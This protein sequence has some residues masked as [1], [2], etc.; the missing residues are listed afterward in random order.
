MSKIFKYRNL[1]S[2][3]ITISLL[4]S[5]P[6]FALAANT[7]DIKEQLSVVIQGEFGPA[8][9]ETYVTGMVQDNFGNTYIVGVTKSQF[10][11]EDS[12]A[13]RERVFLAKF[14]EDLEM[15][16][17]TVLI[18]D[19]PTYS[20]EDYDFAKEEKVHY[21]GNSFHN[22]PITTDAKGNIYIV[23]QEK[24][25]RELT[26][27]IEDIMYDFPDDCICWMWCDEYDCDF[28][29][30]TDCPVCNAFREFEATFKEG[31]SLEYVLYKF[32]SSIEEKHKFIIASVQGA[33]PYNS[34][35]IAIEIDDDGY[36]YVGGGTEKDL[37][38]ADPV[39]DFNYFDADPTGSGKKMDNTRGFLVKINPSMTK[40]AASTY[41]GGPLAETQWSS[42]PDCYVTAIAADSGYIYVA[43]TDGGG[44][45]PTVAEDV[46][47][48]KT[49]N[50]SDVYIV[51]FNRDDLSI[52]KATYYGGTSSDDVTQLTV[53][54]A[55]YSGMVYI[56]GHTTS[57]TIPTHSSAFQRSL[58]TSEANYRDAF[59]ARFSKSLEMD[60]SF[61]ATY[62]GGSQRE[63][64]FGMDV[65]DDG[66][67][68]IT[69]ETYGSY[70]FPTTDGT[71]NSDGRIFI[72]KLNKDFSD[73]VVST[74][75]GGDPW[76]GDEQ[77]RAIKAN[78]DGIVVAGQGD[79]DNTD[80]A[81]P[82][83]S[84]YNTTLSHSRVIKMEATPSGTSRSPIYMGIGDVIDIKVIFDSY[85]AV[86]TTNG[87]PRIKL[88]VGENSYA[89]Y[90]SGSGTNTLTFKYTIVEGDTT[91]GEPLSC[92][93]F[94]LEL[95]GGTI[96]PRSGGTDE[97]INLNLPSDDLSK[98]YIYVSTVPISVDLISSSIGEGTYGTGTV[99]PIT[100][101][102]KDKIL[103]VDT[104]NGTPELSLNNGGKAVFVEKLK[105]KDTDLI[106]NYTVGENQTID[107]LNIASEDALS[108]NGAVIKDYYGIT[109]NLTLPSPDPDE[110]KR[111]LKGKGIRINSNA[112][113][114][115]SVT[116]T[117]E[118]GAYTVGQEI[119]ITLNFDK[120]INKTGTISL[121]INSKKD[122]GMISHDQDIENSESITFNYVVQD[123]DITKDGYLDYSNEFLVSQDGELTS[124]D[125][126]P[127]SITMPKPGSEKSLST[128]KIIIDTETP[129]VQYNYKKPGVSVFKAGDEITLEAQFNE[130]V[131]LNSDITPYV[132]VDYTTPGEVEKARFEYI[133]LKPNDPKTVL[134]RYTVKDEDTL[135]KK[136]VDYNGWTIAPKGCFVDIAGN[137]AIL[138]LPY[139]ASPM[140]R[141]WELTFDTVSPTWGEG[142]L[143]CTYDEAKEAVKIEWPKAVDDNSGIGNYYYIY[144][145][146]KGKD[147]QQISSRSSSYTSYEDK[148]IVPGTTYIYSVYVEDKA[149]NRSEPLVSEEITIPGEKPEEDTMPPYW[150]SG[151][152]LIGERLS[153]TKAKLSWNPTMAVDDDGEVDK[154]EIHQKINNTWD[155]EPL[156][157]IR[158]DELY[159]VKE[160][161]IEGI[162]NDDYEFGIF[163]VDGA[164]HKSDEPLTIVVKR[165]LP[166]MAVVDI[167]TQTIKKEYLLGDLVKMDIKNIRYSGL[168]DRDGNLYRS[169]YG[170]TGI[171]LETI[172]EDLGLLESYTRMG[173][174]AFDMSVPFTLTKEQ[175]EGE[176]YYFAGSAENKLPVKPMIA[177]FY[178]EKNDSYNEPPFMEDPNQMPP[179][180]G[181]GAGPRLFYG[182]RDYNEPNRNNFV[183][184]IYYIYVD[185]PEDPLYNKKPTIH[186]VT[187]D[188]LYIEVGGTVPANEVP[189]KNDV[190]ATDAYGIRIFEDRITRKIA[191]ETEPDKELS[192]I[193]ATKPG[194]YIVTYTAKDIRDNV[195][196]VT[197]KVIIY[198]PIVPKGIYS[199][200]IDESEEYEISQ[201]SQ[202]PTI[203]SLIGE[204]KEIEFSANITPIISYDEGTETVLFAHTR[205][206]KMI[207][208]CA[209]KGQ[210]F[211]KDTPV[212]GSF[213]M[214][215]GDKVLIYVV[216]KI[217]GLRGNGTSILFE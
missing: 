171:T 157:I 53:T 76:S 131:Y 119:P 148:A 45:I 186:N 24:V 98:K 122:Y 58:N 62:I 72:T 34:R 154:L 175:I 57:P 209:I 167:K 79:F 118:E 217:D 12:K 133:G 39:Y 78:D 2:I 210:D 73:L 81:R 159:T 55:V 163:I 80:T 9:K 66:N 60:D 139:T 41:L 112:A 90:V 26:T 207:G 193:D 16:D 95:N 191:L 168:S 103:S 190:V 29:D 65:D 47:K 162:T 102:F 82:F 87:T 205:G 130:E 97:D 50:D 161:I 93:E 107:E 164:G 180:F 101:R 6:G 63:D 67:V 64:L 178:T 61:K 8:A 146:V 92:D 74:I 172:L 129:F 109:P 70:S 179:G 68:Y 182:Q 59:V 83:V 142:T 176:Q 199:V 17:Y 115:L 22:S 20:P 132:E 25:S 160:Y 36:I 14:D 183:K 51:R 46:Y 15:V 216:D 136:R 42:G 200:I 134:F 147:S 35:T 84:R 196:V 192:R 158:K 125:G 166:D 169:W 202:V 204:E 94:A 113:R 86:D 71:S 213:V 214:K 165:E 37:G 108:L 208:L 18:G 43:G 195:A 189:A 174:R 198:K 48:E 52:D 212:N 33:N 128:A 69:G 11:E 121:S 54:G 99:I 201:D 197:K 21:A 123:G 1:L 114:I 38:F 184:D 126:Y 75:V 49:K 77:G 173:F 106:F 203:V 140:L 141:P 211:K 56:G 149:G 153:S 111:T 23:T 145:A 10:G 206:N 187:E 110:E 177:L 144:R 7:G 88:N 31:S 215:K 40:I 28:G 181:V 117:L 89:N 96:L 137:E 32:D 152:E 143:I 30:T 188:D 27:S 151:A 194:T 13:T 155:T 4:L 104:T 116:T 19:G 156:K 44:K 185:F 100:V 91:N 150:V 85:V 120:P 170:A 5:M 124:V 3:V 135:M 105:D 138:A 127:V